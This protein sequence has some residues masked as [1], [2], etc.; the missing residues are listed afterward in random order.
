MDDGGIISSERRRP[1]APIPH[2]QQIIISKMFRRNQ[3]FSF[4]PA[5]LECPRRRVLGSLLTRS[6]SSAHCCTA[7]PS[8]SH[9]HR[10]PPHRLCQ[11]YKHFS[12]KSLNQ[13]LNYL[14]HES[15]HSSTPEKGYL[16]VPQKTHP[17]FPHCTHFWQIA[18]LVVVS[19]AF[20]SRCDLSGRHPRP[21]YLPLVCALPISPIQQETPL[22]ECFGS[23]PYST[24]AGQSRYVRFVTMSRSQRT[25]RGPVPSL[26]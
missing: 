18:S 17:L 19:F 12:T 5:R 7:P 23:S 16:I 25:L 11:Q 20:D 15:P 9:L 2:H 4:S 22:L 13:A 3:L 8:P 21:I 1:S 6:A 10:E 24:R 26:V 14:I